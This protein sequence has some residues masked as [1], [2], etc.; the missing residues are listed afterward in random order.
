MVLVVG[1]LTPWEIPGS[2]PWLSLALVLANLCTQSLLL[3]FAN[4]YIALFKVLVKSR[5]NRFINSLFLLKRLEIYGGCL[6]WWVRLH[7]EWLRP[8]LEYQESAS[9]SASSSSFL[10]CM[11]WKVADDSN[12]W[13]AAMHVGDLDTVPSLGF[14]PAPDYFKHLGNE[15]VDRHSFYIYFCPSASLSLLCFFQSLS[16]SLCLP[17]Q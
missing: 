14:W 10:Q 8:V 15:K 6:P 11:F 16:L 13:V 3:C 9:G 17:F 1:F 5:I 12:S 7:L 2:W 4:K